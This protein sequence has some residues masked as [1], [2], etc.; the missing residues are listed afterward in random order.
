MMVPAID[1]ITTTI[2]QRM[3][4]RPNKKLLVSHEIAYP[5]MMTKY[6]Y[7]QAPR[8]RENQELSVSF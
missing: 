3:I 6:K 5:L 2:V 4:L 1:K 7:P 8:N